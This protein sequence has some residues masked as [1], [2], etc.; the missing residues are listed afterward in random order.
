M[1]VCGRANCLVLSIII[2]YALVVTP[3]DQFGSPNLR[4]PDLRHGITLAA[5]ELNR[6]NI[7]SVTVF[8]NE[9]IDN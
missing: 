5:A 7:P 8:D 4:D 6:A 3:V 1:A 2:I 9:I